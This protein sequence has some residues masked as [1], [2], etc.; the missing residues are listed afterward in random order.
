MDPVAGETFWQGANWPFLVAAAVAVPEIVKFVASLLQRSRI[1][2]PVPEELKGIYD[3]EENDTSLRYSIA[4][5]TFG[6]W[7]TFFSA[8]VFFGFWL[9]G[10]FP[11]L[12][13]FCC[14]LELSEVSTGVVYITLL[15]GLQQAL[16]IPWDLY[17]TFVLEEKF[18]FNKT[19]A[20]TFAKDRVKGVLLYL[21]LGVPVLAVVLWFLGSF[22]TGAWF[23]VWSFITAVQVIMLI[24][25]PVLILPLFM[26]MIP[27]PDGQA[28]ILEDVGA[29][30]A[31]PPFLSGRVFYA[32]EPLQNEKAWT[33]RDRRFAGAKV[34]EQLVLRRKD[35][36]WVI[37]SARG[38]DVQIYATANGA[39]SF[40]DGKLSFQITEEAKKLVEAKQGQ[41]SSDPLVPRAA[42]T[43]NAACVEAGSLRRS[44]LEM[45]DSLGYKGASIFVIDGSARSSHS[46]AF[47]TGF[48]S[49]R[50]ICLFDTLLPIMSEGEI[51]AVLGHEIGHDR[52]YHVHTRLISQILY[53]F[54]ML[55]VLGNFLL[56]PALSAAFFAQPKVYLGVVF[57]SIIWEPV[58]FPLSVLM[59][60]LSRSHEYQAD[61]FSVRAGR[62]NSRLLGEAL[63]KL[64]KKSKVNLTPHPFH[65]FLNNSHPPLDTRLQAIRDYHEKYYSCAA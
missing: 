38:E 26:E 60:L 15:M 37:C 21:L 6:L 1:G 12:D 45:A 52:L 48:G 47:C 18:G 16:D 22:G 65:V 36:S 8:G 11:C 13:G 44:L 34:G 28:I 58:D 27:L 56:S 63:K 25:L 50:R 46:N 31:L 35:G 24:L 5:S 39:G 64:M 43:V 29:D 49:F 51:L 55:Y 10:G 9:L 33:T 42:T 2:S 54:V 23:W 7:H 20:A 41:A 32:D 3:E 59:Q 57:F 17:F 40:A 53:L 4:K 30:Q 14:G 19:T 62:E 61:R